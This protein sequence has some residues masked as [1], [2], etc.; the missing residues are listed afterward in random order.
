MPTDLAIVLLVLVPVELL[1]LA[2]W[3]ASRNSSLQTVSHAA[4]PQ[5]VE[6]A[7]AE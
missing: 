2:T 6:K 7:V 4:D 3:E 5:P 1:V